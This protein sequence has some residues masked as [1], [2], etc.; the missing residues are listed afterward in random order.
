MDCQKVGEVF[1]EGLENAIAHGSKNECPV[2][3]GL[4]M[5]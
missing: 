3:Y 2:F 1:V 5:G 4:F